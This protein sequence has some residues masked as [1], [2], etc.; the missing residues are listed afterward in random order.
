MVVGRP[1][2]GSLEGLTGVIFAE[3]DDRLPLPLEVLPN[4]LLV[5]PTEED[6]RKLTPLEESRHRFLKINLNLARQTQNLLR[7]VRAF[8]LFAVAATALIFLSVS[9]Q[10]PISTDDLSYGATINSRNASNLVGIFHHQQ[11]STV[12]DIALIPQDFAKFPP[13][14]SIHRSQPALS[15]LPNT[16]A[17]GVPDPRCSK[18]TLPPAFQRICQPPSSDT[19]PYRP[20]KLSLSP[21]LE[22]A[23][24]AQAPSK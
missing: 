15:K 21:A 14:N 20:V 11:L 24:L 4:V 1:L 23:M 19:V 22:G 5:A 8:C 3:E 10:Q 2:R 13:V 7:S 18:N 16:A 9:L 6:D 17:L 12:C